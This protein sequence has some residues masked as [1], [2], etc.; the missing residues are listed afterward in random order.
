MKN[1][2]PILL[3][4]ILKARS[5]QISKL[6]NHSGNETLFGLEMASSLLYLKIINRDP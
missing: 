2:N 3:Q 5:P 1:C 6:A 4:Y